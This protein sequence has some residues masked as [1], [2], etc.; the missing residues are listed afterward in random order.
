[1]KVSKLHISYFIR[2]INIVYKG[3]NFPGM[4]F[5][6]CRLSAERGYKLIIEPVSRKLIPVTNMFEK[7]SSHL[8]TEVLIVTL[9]MVQPANRLDKFERIIS[10]PC[11]DRDNALLSPHFLQNI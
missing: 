4:I 3:N 8:F 10:R 5:R 1:M 2:F 6:L 11:Y 7:I 9:F